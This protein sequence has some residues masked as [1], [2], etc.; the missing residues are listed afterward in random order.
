MPFD[1]LSPRSKMIRT[2]RAEYETK[3]KYID[4]AIQQNLE[5]IKQG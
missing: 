5:I 1:Q 3:Q 4:K 2:T